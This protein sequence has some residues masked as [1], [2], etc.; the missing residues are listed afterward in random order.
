MPEHNGFDHAWFRRFRKAA[1]DVCQCN[2]YA[3]H[4][5]EPFKDDQNRR[6]GFWVSVDFPAAEVVGAFLFG[7]SIG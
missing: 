5:S 1:F 2:V 6:V 3:S 7:V 4:C